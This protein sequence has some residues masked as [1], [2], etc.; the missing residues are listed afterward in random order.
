MIAGGPRTRRAFLARAA[1]TVPLLVVAPALLRAQPSSTVDMAGDFYIPVRPA[2]KP[3]A[4]ASLDG[5]AINTLERTLACPCPCTLDI[6]TCRTTDVTCTNSPAIHRDVVR[7]V[8][9]GYSGDE[10]V[11]ELTNVYGERILMAPRKSG[12]NLVAWFLPFVAIGTGGVAIAVLLRSWRNNARASATL[13]TDGT[14]R[15]IRAQGSDEEMAR[16]NAALRDDSR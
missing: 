15:P 2:P 16:L 10:I 5:D 13:M 6:Y 3:G 14:V 12:F 4:T 7:M 1:A 11:A 8:D 9:G